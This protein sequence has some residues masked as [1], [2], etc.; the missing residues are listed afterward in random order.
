VTVLWSA[1]LSMLFTELPY[2]E[3]PQAARAA[4][5]A[6]VE[7][8]WPPGGLADAWAAEVR[9]CG[10]AVTCLNCDGGS[11]EA[12]ERGFLNDPGRSDE[13]V[14]AF[15]AAARLAHAVRAPR[16][17][18]LVGRELR[19][20]PPRD[21]LAL[22]LAVV[23]ECAAIAE[24]ERLTLLVEP[25]NELDVPGYLLPTAARAAA[26]VEQVGS[27]AVRLLYDAYHAAR[28]GGHPST[29]VAQLIGLVDH[30][31][32]ADCP[33]RGAPGTGSLDLAELVASL[34]AAGYDGAVGLEFDPRGP[35]LQALSS[36][37]S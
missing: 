6:A 35:T 5:F 24:R 37:P 30:V 21:Q 3:R 29:E 34:E 20:A 14:R 27:G 10:L 31:H 9:R 16:V 33:G 4:G 8:W 19:G 22:A 11:I 1:H 26:F 17:N 32:Y 25:I 15:R 23:R 28:A 7:T 2:L 12:G 13:A 18:L 36:L